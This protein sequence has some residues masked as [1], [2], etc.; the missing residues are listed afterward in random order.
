MKKQLALIFLLFTFVY[1]CNGQTKTITTKKQYELQTNSDSTSNLLILKR[2]AIDL[3][4]ITSILDDR[5]TIILAVKVINKYLK[6]PQSTFLLK[7]IPK[8][9]HKI[10]LLGKNNRLFKDSLTDTFYFKA[11][12]NGKTIKHKLPNLRF[13]NANQIML[14]VTYTFCGAIVVLLATYRGP[15]F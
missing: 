12:G 6:A 10:V 1:N 2:R 15:Q 5:D 4:M 13:N 7:N 9:D 3:P 8:G 11:T 14:G